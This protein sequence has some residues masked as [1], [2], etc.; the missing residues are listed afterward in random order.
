MQRLQGVQ[1]VNAEQIICICIA[2]PVALTIIAYTV[3]AVVKD[4]RE[5]IRKELE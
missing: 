4:E 2:A 5:A 3:R 1:T